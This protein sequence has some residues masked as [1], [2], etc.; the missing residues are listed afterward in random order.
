MKTLIILRHADAAEKAAGTSDFDR[1]LTDT[2]RAQASRQGEFLRHAGIGM[3]RVVASAAQRAV[4][5]AEALTEA[6]G[7]GL[8]V[9]PVQEL[10]NAPGD[11]LLEYVRGLPNDCSTLLMVA[12]LPGIA[13]LLSLLT[14]EHVDLDQIFSPA[15]LAAVQVDG[16]SWKDFDYGVGSLALFL[17]PFLS[18]D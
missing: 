3:E 9:E 16:D 5:T 17:P 15:T 14:T 2:G 8:A 10:Y 6:S 18:V 12:H 11:A 13:E 1:P 4:D 7:T